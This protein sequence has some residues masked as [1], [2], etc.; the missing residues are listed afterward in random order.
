MLFIWLLA[1]RK[2]GSCFKWLYST[3]QLCD[4]AFYYSRRHDRIVEIISNFTKESIQRYRIHID[5]HST[6]V[7]PLLGDQLESI[8]HKKPDIHVV[9]HLEKKCFIIIIIITMIIIIIIIIIIMSELR[10]VMR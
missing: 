1:Y 10:L 3:L 7:F 6:I 2:H 4:H 5:K 8:E 9:N